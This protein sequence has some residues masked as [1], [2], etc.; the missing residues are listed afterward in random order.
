LAVLE[1]DVLVIRQGRQLIVRADALEGSMSLRIPDLPIKIRETTRVR[2]ASP[3][4]ALPPAQLAP[5]HM[6]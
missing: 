1:R 3:N 4:P 5:K 2:S 6:Q